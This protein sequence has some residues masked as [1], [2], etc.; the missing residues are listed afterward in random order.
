MHLLEL[1]LSLCRQE[2]TI[3]AHGATMENAIAA[4]PVTIGPLADAAS[5]AITP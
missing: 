4:T 5:I 2:F 1:M 3:A